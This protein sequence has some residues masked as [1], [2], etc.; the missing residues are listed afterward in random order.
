MQISDPVLDGEPRMVKRGSDE[1]V[2]A[3]Y[4]NG[5]RVVFRGERS[6][7]EGERLLTVLFPC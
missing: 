2:Q 4:I 3:V 5:V 1:I 6:R 7:L